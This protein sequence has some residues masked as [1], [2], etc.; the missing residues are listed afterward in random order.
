[1]NLMD[2]KPGTGVVRRLGNQH[3]NAQ[4]AIATLGNDDPQS[5]TL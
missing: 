3:G 2:I 5:A 4:A 1:V